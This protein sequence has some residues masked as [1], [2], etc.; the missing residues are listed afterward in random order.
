[1]KNKHSLEHNVSKFL[2][3]VWYAILIGASGLLLTWVIKLWL[4]VLGVI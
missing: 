1:M 3:F 2:A 4:T